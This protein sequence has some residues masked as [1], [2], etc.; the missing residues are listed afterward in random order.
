MNVVLVYL[1]LLFELLQILQKRLNTAER[2]CA[3]LVEAEV[4][5][6]EHKV[7]QRVEL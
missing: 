7:L 1:S 3:H 2:D 5:S 4:D 6:L